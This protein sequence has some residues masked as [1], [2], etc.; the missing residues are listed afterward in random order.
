MRD[1]FSDRD[2]GN[3]PQDFMDDLNKR[4]DERERHGFFGPWNGIM[5]VLLIILL[6]VFPLLPSSNADQNRN[7]A[8]LEKQSSTFTPTESS[9]E[10]EDSSN[11]SIVSG[12]NNQSNLE[13]QVNE[14]SSKGEGKR[15]TVREKTTLKSNL[16]SKSLKSTTTKTDGFKK[17]SEF[18]GTVNENKDSS[19]QSGTKSIYK[20]SSKK[21]NGGSS[22]NIDAPKKADEEGTDEN[23]NYIYG[24][25]SMVL[26][27]QHTI[28]ESKIRNWNF[29]PILS[30]S[31]SNVHAVSNNPEIV[32]YSPFSWELQLSSGL[33]FPTLVNSGSTNGNSIL[34]NQQSGNA[35]SYTIGGRVTLW[36]NKLSF[37][38]GA[39]LLSIKEENLFELE[40]VTSYDSTYITNVDTMVVFDSTNQSWDT[41][42]T[43]DYDSTTVTDTT[44]S[45]VPV[46]QQYSWIQI[47]LQVGYKFQFNKWAIIPRAGVNLAFGIRQQNKAYPNAAF[48]GL[49]TYTPTAKV[50]MNLSGSLEVRREINNWHIFARGDYQSG[51]RPILTGDY[52]D[53]RYNGFRINFGIGLTLD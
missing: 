24:A 3:P 5:D 50:L 14:N 42:Y 7:I 41:T 6:F 40:Q 51:M 21:E 23:L 35:P 49:Q 8:E 47:P 44:I 30:S 45:T 9:D 28:I 1:R 33:N 32:P 20:T 11:G 16:A 43:Y 52:F 25:N 19:K 15:N 18:Q 22:N 10:K 34:L 39:D 36:Y 38:S 27:T 46:S 2:F 48:D 17:N 37:T 4:L 29:P 26:A 13:N 31:N 12:Q 53:R